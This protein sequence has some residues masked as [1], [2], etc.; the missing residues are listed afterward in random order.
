MRT[1][2]KPGLVALLALLLT[3]Q[4]CSPIHVRPEDPKPV[5]VV[6]VVANV[7]IWT[8]GIAAVV[9]VIAVVVALAARPAASP[10]PRQCQ[11]TCHQVGQTVQCQQICN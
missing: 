8:V 10:P 5:Q 6:K 7:S 11:T 4:A 1:F 9:A 2:L 3:L